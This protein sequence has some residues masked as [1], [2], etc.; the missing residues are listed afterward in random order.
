MRPS[1]A[2]RTALRNAS[3]PLQRCIKPSLARGLRSSSRTAPI[4]S[5][6][7]FSCRSPTQYALQNGPAARRSFHS[8]PS[9]DP[10]REGLYYHPT[11]APTPAS[12]DQPAFALS[13]L[14]SPPPHADSSTIIG[15]L[16]ATG[17]SGSPEGQ[18]AGLKD[19]VENPKF[20]DILH[21]AVQEG[22]R[23]GVDDIQING[24]TQLQEGW[25]H[26]HDD[27]NI[28]PLGRIGDPDDII[29]S[30]RVQD[31]KIMPETYQA[32]P[33]YRICTAD[34]LT[35]LTPGLAQ[36]LQ[37]HLLKQAEAEGAQPYISTWV[38]EYIL[39]QK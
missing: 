20:R 13:F 21:K 1:S 29:A 38:F 15:W 12:R 17:T 36:E 2:L 31:G 22:L 4:P 37:K 32:M 7:A 9:Q 23:K 24:A 14:E 6:T 28:P 34:G 8:A 10:N 18:E 26:I 30:V 19:F 35:Q 33:A 27:R 3:R 5:F 25:M 39:H 16:P 11:P